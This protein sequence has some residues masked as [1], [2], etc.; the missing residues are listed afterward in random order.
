[1]HCKNKHCKILNY[2][3]N[4]DKKICGIAHYYERVVDLFCSKALKVLLRLIQNLRSQQMLQF[5]CQTR[6]LIKI[7]ASK[8]I[9][10]HRRLPNYSIVELFIDTTFHALKYTRCTVILLCMCTMII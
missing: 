6:W 9:S 3:N 5:T 10:E 7:I 1:M 4:K 8:I 2:A